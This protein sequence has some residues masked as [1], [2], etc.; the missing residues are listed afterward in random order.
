MSIS[1]VFR[2]SQKSQ[3]HAHSINELIA[4]KMNR[5]RYQI[6]FCIPAGVLMAVNLHAT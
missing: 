5:F 6:Y 2:I 1:P 4:S 3:A